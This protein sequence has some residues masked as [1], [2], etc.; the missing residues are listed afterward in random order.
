MIIRSYRSVPQCKHSEGRQMPF[1]NTANTMLDWW[2][3]RSLEN[4][5]KYTVI[6]HI[7]IYNHILLYSHTRT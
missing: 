6:L 2:C 3:D 4:Y 5:G 7:I 1:G